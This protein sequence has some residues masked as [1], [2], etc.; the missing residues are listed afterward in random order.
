MANK[1]TYIWDLFENNI[2]KNKI[3][4]S[5]HKINN[6][7]SKTHKN[8]INL[9]NS[10]NNLY[11]S[12]T[13]IIQ[14]S[15]LPIST[16]PI[17]PIE[18]Y[19]KYIYNLQKKVWIDSSTLT[20]LQ[21]DKYNNIYKIL[22]KSGNNNH[23]IQTN[24]LNQPKYHNGS[25]IFNNNN[26]YL[27]N[28]TLSTIDKYTIILICKEYNDNPTYP[29]GVYTIEN[30]TI[31][32]INENNYI[33]GSN[34]I[35]EIYELFVFD[36]ILDIED[37]I[38]IEKYLLNKWNTV[39]NPSIV[40]VPNIYLWADISSNL[41]YIQDQFKNLIEQPN[42]INETKFINIISYS[43]LDLTNCSIFMVIEDEKYISD[44]LIFSSNNFI[45]STNFINIK[46]KNNFKRL[47]EF[48]INND[49][50]K[51][52][53]DGKVNNKKLPVTKLASTTNNFTINANV[54]IKQIIILND[55]P[56]ASTQNKLY[57]YF[58]EKWNIDLSYVLSNNTISYIN[59][60]IPRAKSR[61]NN[62]ISLN[63]IFSNELEL[64]I[65]D[66]TD[67]STNFN[68]P[69]PINITERFPNQ[70]TIIDDELFLTSIDFGIIY[71]VKS[72]INDIHYNNIHL[73]ASI[74]EH[75]IFAF[76]NVGTNSFTIK[77]NT[78][79]Y[80]ID[81][82]P[83]NTHYFT[84]SN[85][86]Y[87]YTQNIPK[88]QLSLDKYDTISNNNFTI[89]LN[90]WIDVINNLQLSLTDENN[91]THTINTN[92]IY[93]DGCYKSDFNLL[94]PI[95]TYNVI[96]TNYNITLEKPIIITR[97]IDAILK[98]TNLN[99]KISSIITLINWND[100]YKSINNLDIYINNKY[101]VNSKIT[102]KHCSF[103]LDSYPNG[104]YWVTIQDKCNLIHLNIPYPI[105]NNPN[106]TLL[107]PTHKTNEYTILIENWQNKICNFNDILY[108]YANTILLDKVPYNLI[109]NDTI[110]IESHNKLQISESYSLC[111]TDSPIIN[112]HTNIYLPVKNIIPSINIT[113]VINK[114]YG[115]I[116]S[117]NVFII[118]LSASENYDLESYSRLWYI[119]V[120]S[121]NTFE[122][123]T[124]TFLNNNNLIFTYNP[125]E[126]SE[127]KKFYISNN[128]DCSDIKIS[129]TTSLPYLQINN[130]EITFNKISFN[131]TNNNNIYTIRLDG[132]TSNIDIKTLYIFNTFS[133]ELLTD[134]IIYQKNK[135]DTNTIFYAD[136][137]YD[138]IQ[139]QNYI[140]ICD[141]DNMSGYIQEIINDPIIYTPNIKL[142]LILNSSKLNTVNFI[143]Q[144][145]NILNY[146][147]YLNIY[148]SYNN[149]YA[150]LQFITKS[151]IINTDNVYQV[152]F[153]IPEIIV[154]NNIHY[155]ISYSDKPNPKN[156][157]IY[158]KLI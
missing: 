114:N 149:K 103:N 67:L 54:K 93:F 64:T 113:A 12:Q 19:N 38:T 157:V 155:Y 61:N 6:N 132:W 1:N 92:L 135:D 18:T 106:V 70:L 69:I 84:F 30:N 72:Y 68:L 71:N 58:S 49:K 20:S 98:Y 94:L 23:F 13:N 153:I 53:I 48:H 17:N 129:V 133:N 28:T 2:K 105:I 107:N 90:G 29:Y 139:M 22:D 31:L 124:N 87:I 4:N 134:A 144:P 96:V 46:S 145:N 81:P 138:F 154:T 79:N 15:N 101:Y 141:T 56:S 128:N 76:K 110:Q 151:L 119:F 63:T 83:I 5:Y 104:F 89:Y 47:H 10:S 109:Q 85:S 111:I 34:F 24:I 3:I 158:T 45:I 118:T 74:P 152:T 100:D 8:T 21:R 121:N 26:N 148:Y 80:I 40:S 36:Q 82:N 142:N 25:I 16:Y 77:F 137:S 125:L 123:L 9:H 150:N 73:P 97:S 43:N 126:N 42:L 115:F 66:T 102:D 127:N 120:D 52:Y 146:Y 140:T 86:T 122:L 57:N 60:Y 75:N 78:D 27:L 44:Q 108:V 143:V 59:Q 37:K 32:N 62:Y 112:E 11:L 55:L 156:S 136:F 131:I 147:E 7:S 41:I 91:N 33:L 116:N 130:N 117:D 35:G 14:P 99:N 95:G 39:Q 65:S 88:L 50:I 51:Y